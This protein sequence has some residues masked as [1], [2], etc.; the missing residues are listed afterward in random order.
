MRLQTADKIRLVFVP[1]ILFDDTH[2]TIHQNLL[3]GVRDQI[4]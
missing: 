3:G 4:L 1:Q 2:I